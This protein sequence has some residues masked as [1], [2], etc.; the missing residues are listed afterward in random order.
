MA[1]KFGDS[2]KKIRTEKKV[3]QQE[4]A[5]MIGMHSTHISRYERNQAAPSIDVV[6]KIAESLDVSID[7]LIYG[8]ED[9]KAKSNLK[10]NE[11]LNM[12]SKVQQ[13]D[14]DNVCIPKPRTQAGNA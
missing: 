6:Q 10:D 1:D 4:L 9:D 14:S 5:D 11:L 12:F 7:T 8:N 3:S 13:L 2:L